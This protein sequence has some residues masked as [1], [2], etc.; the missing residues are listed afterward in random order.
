MTTPPTLFITGAGPGTGKSTV[1]GRIH[2]AF[3]HR[4]IPVHCWYETE[5]L[6]QTEFLPFFEMF[7]L[8]DPEMAASL[9]RAL[10]SYL[11]RHLV[12]AGAFISES[13]IPCVRWLVL[14]MVPPEKI[15]EFCAWLSGRLSDRDPTLVV[16][17]CSASVGIDRARSER[18]KQWHERWRKRTRD[19]PLYRSRPDLDRS[20]VFEQELT[21][22]D[23]LGWP[24]LDF[25]T[26]RTAEADI[27]G[28]TLNCFALPLA[29]SSHAV[30]LAEGTY[31]ALNDDASM[32]E[33]EISR[34]RIR[35]RGTWLDLNGR[36]DG[37]ARIERTNSTIRRSAEGLEL[38]SIR[39]GRVTYQ[40]AS[41]GGVT[42]ES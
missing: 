40:P 41:H 32:H 21:Y 37:S 28:A 2:T 7:R 25:D 36:S 11:D 22:F 9:K 26:E 16:L 39:L 1:A 13:L 33:I 14:G 8:G 17:S 42:T 15:L 29:S 10:D 24:R 4:E 34:N 3:E 23:T 35:I 20:F 38:S 5:V 12:D 30:N 18:G 27:V 6:Q 31:R 19:Y